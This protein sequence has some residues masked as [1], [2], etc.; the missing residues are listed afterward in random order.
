MEVPS[1]P[2]VTQ[3]RPC[4]LN[5]FDPCPGERCKRR[6]LGQEGRIAARDDLA[7]GLLEHDLR[8]QDLV[9]VVRAPPREVA[10]TAFEP[11]EERNPNRFR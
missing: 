3:A 6:E 4:R 11:L 1:P 2:V 5:L 9:R 7:P 10:S 8:D